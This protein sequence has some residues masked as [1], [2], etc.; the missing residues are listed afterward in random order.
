MFYF[1]LPIIFY[2]IRLIA[3]GEAFLILCFTLTALFFLTAPPQGGTRPEISE[4]YLLNAW[5]G[6]IRLA[7]VFWPFFLLL[8]ASLLSADLLAKGGH[9][10]VSSWDDIHFILILP[11]IWW[12]VSIWRSS[13]NTGLRIWA[14]LARAVTLLV[15]V[16]YGFK[17]AIRIDYPRLFFH[18]EE[19][20]LNYGN[21]F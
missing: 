19:L 14:V 8:N 16:E 12:A 18:C 10:T 21:C 15:V 4:H 9:I 6:N 20:L 17:L 13:Q 7:P 1:S 3:P 5:L 11:F 2:D